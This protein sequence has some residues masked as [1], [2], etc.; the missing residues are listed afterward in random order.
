[1]ADIYLTS[2]E[3]TLLIDVKTTK[4]SVHREA[5]EGLRIGRRVRVVG[6]CDEM[7]D[8]KYIGVEGTIVDRV[9]NDVGA[10]ERD[11]MWVVWIKGQG[12]DG[13]WGEELEVT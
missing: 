5:P 2:A 4:P 10:T 6:G 8:A 11:P 7:F 3:G 1:M 13:F 12:K 9:T